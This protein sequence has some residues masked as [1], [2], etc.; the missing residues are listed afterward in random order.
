[1]K[2]LFEQLLRALWYDPAAALLWL[3]ILALAVVV[4][5]LIR[6]LARW[7]VLQPLLHAI[8][9]D[10]TA[11]K[12]WLWGAGGFLVTLASGVFIGSTVEE[13]FTWPARRWMAQIVTS[14]LA[15]TLGMINP[16][17]KKSAPAPESAVQ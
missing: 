10:P 8:W 7:P 13:A 12:R 16:A 3:K 15:L 2:P 4:V 1:M 6:G 5:V 17:T 11:V 9:Y 14:L